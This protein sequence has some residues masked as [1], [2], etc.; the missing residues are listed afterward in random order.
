MGSFMV[1]MAIVQPLLVVFATV[2]SRKLSLDELREA[3]GA[4]AAAGIDVKRQ[5]DVILT[6]VIV[7]ARAHKCTHP[8]AH[9]SM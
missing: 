8:C 6:F 5:F 9:A 2:F 1:M 7:Y 3:E 4:E